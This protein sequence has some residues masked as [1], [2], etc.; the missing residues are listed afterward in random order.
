MGREHYSGVSPLNMDARRR[1]P[2]GAQQHAGNDFCQ[3]VEL[4]FTIATDS[5]HSFQVARI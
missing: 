5:T 2:E 1:K 3:V 4:R